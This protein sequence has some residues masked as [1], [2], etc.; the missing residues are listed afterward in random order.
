M[1]RRKPSRRRANL[2]RAAVDE[3]GMNLD[4][5]VMFV[6]STAERGVV[7]SGT[8]LRFFQNGRRV[9]ARYGGGRVLR[10]CLAGRISGSELRF[11]FLQVEAPGEIHGGASVCQVRRRANGRIRILENFTWRTRAGSGI[12]VFDEVAD[13]GDS[14]GGDKE[15]LMAKQLKCGELMPGCAAVFEGKDESEVM[16]SAARH[17]KDAHGIAEVTPD[18]AAKVRSAIRE[19]G[20]AQGA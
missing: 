17:A 3:T 15:V 13:A 4:G 19:K 6:S 8:R 12:N 20:S 10:G 7:D 14:I 18:L 5:L 16:A 2:A 9:R 1:A 11:R